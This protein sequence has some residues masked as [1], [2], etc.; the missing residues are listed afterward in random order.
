MVSKAISYLESE[1]G[2]TGTELQRYGL[3]KLQFAASKSVKK[4]PVKA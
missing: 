4:A 1:Y 2:K 3:S